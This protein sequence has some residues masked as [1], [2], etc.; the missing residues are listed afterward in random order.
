M[1]S[2]FGNRETL[3]SQIQKTQDKHLKSDAIEAGDLANAMQK[4]YG[5]RLVD[6]IEEHRQ[7]AK[8]Y[9]IFVVWTKPPEYMRRAIYL[10]FVVRNTRPAME[11]D[12]DC[13]YVNNA[14]EELRL[15][16]SLPHWSDFDGILAYED[17]YD[18]DLVKWIK[19]YKKAQKKGVRR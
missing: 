19:I 14:K 3:G 17:K 1:K 6:T 7:L 10:N 13:W 9:Y 12:T 2:E 11:D 15:E 8:P 16:W 5:T 18:K 4:S